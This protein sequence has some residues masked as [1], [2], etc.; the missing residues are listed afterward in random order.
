MSS[1][2]SRLTLIVRSRRNGYFYEFLNKYKTEKKCSNSDSW[3]FFFSLP[4][5]NKSRAANMKQNRNIFAPLVVLVVT[6]I[7]S[8]VSQDDYLLP[9]NQPQ[10]Q[11]RH[12]SLNRARRMYAMCPPD[13]IKIGSECY[14]ISA[15]KESWLDAHF[16]CKDRNSKLAEPLKYADRR[17]RKYLKNRDQSRSD[18]IWIGGMYNWQT[19]KW[20]WGYNGGDMKY[21]SFGDQQVHRWDEGNQSCWKLFN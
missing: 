3:Y 20:Q 7:T 11:L 16:E 21:F 4:Q 17:L 12:P 15:N 9:Q 14:F 8:V 1:C 18:N 13:F 5:S 10:P 6:L 2:A 19:N